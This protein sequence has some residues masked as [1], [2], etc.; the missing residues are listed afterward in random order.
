[1]PGHFVVGAVGFAL[2]RYRAV[3]VWP[4]GLPLLEQSN[5]GIAWPR[6]TLTD[7]PLP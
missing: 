7:A 6:V 2:P 4:M 3:A 5:M 1:M